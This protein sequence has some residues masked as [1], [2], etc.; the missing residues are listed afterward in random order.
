MLG[1]ILTIAVVASAESLFSA[2]AVDRLH[3]GPPTRYN[4]ELIAQGTGNLVSGVLGALPMTAVI[5]R[6]SANVHAGARTK[7]SAVL[8]GIWLL[9]FAVALPGVVGMIPL[10]ALAALLV[11]SGWKLLDPGKLV[12]AARHDRAEAV[13]TV[14]TAGTIAG[15]D[16]LTGVL[17]GLG[18]AILLAAWRLSHVTVGWRH[19]EDGGV[20]VR[21]R[22]NGVFL[23]LPQILRGLEAVPH[24]ARVH[25]DLTDLR[26]L[27]QAT[28]D[29]L[30]SWATQRQRNDAH[31]HTALPQ[32]AG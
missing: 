8:H 3:D 4:A 1:T 5:V 24:A 17:L 19:I 30:E 20:H 27:D 15:I 14:I 13:I 31:V 28:R 25:L 6:S 26:H 11:H 7:A 10:P 2:V 9:V 16:M 23:R 29:T 18:L 32:P 12:R 21:V 22:G